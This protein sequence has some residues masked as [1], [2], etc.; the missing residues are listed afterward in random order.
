MLLDSRHQSPCRFQSH[1]LQLLV[2]LGRCGKDD[3]QSVRKVAVEGVTIRHDREHG[4][5]AN[6]RDGPAILGL[7]GQLLE[8]Q[9][10]NGP[11]LLRHELLQAVEEEVT[12]LLDVGLHKLR[13]QPSDDVG[14]RPGAHSVVEK[15]NHEAGGGAHGLHIVDDRLL[16]GRDEIVEIHG[17]QILGGRVDELCQADANPL[18]HVR[19]AGGEGVHEDRHELRH[20]ALAELADEVA[21][22]ACSHALLLSVRG[23]QA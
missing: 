20:H 12:M 14:G 15:R 7:L 8:H 22:A 4:Q 5:A 11:G 18:A 13:K 9:G 10:Q 6:L 19:V 16:D 17:K 2:T 3:R 1:S 21:D 23:G